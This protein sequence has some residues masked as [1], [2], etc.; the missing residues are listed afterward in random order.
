MKAAWKGKKN[1]TYVLIFLALFFALWY[2]I[3]MKD[4][5]FN[6][7][8]FYDSSNRIPDWNQHLCLVWS[9]IFFNK[10]EIH[11]SL[12]VP[13]SILDFSPGLC[14]APIGSL[15]SLPVHIPS[16]LTVQPYPIRMYFSLFFDGFCSILQLLNTK[17]CFTARIYAVFTCIST[18]FVLYCI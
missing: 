9:G 14:N 12:Q 5:L 10:R 8:C 7:L 11:S 17:K 2:T 15:P 13:L 16:Y 4:N 1:R 3:C 18:G 6:F